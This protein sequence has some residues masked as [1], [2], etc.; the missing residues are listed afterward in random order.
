MLSKVDYQQYC[1]IQPI[2]EYLQVFLQN[3]FVPVSLWEMPKKLVR[4]EDEDFEASENDD[5]DQQV[6][7]YEEDEGSIEGEDNELIDQG[8]EEKTMSD[9]E[10]EEDEVSAGDNLMDDENDQEVEGTSR[11]K[12]G[13]KAESE[14]EEKVIPANVS[15]SRQPPKSFWKYNESSSDDDDAPEEVGNTS[16]KQETLELYQRQKEAAMAQL[17]CVRSE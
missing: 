10:V 7:D 12:K 15:A 6:G 4:H 14:T 2:L 3:H 13:L 8:D 1:I 17:L 9:K 16:K 5:F 11:N